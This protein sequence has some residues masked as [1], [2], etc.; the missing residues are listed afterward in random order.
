MAFIGNLSNLRSENVKS[1]IN[2]RIKTDKDNQSADTSMVTLLQQ[3]T[4][5][6]SSRHA[7]SSVATAFKKTLIKFRKK[8]CK[9]PL[10]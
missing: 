5:Y 3:V 7:K 6:E 10:Q 8:E 1:V 2:R 4:D 9:I